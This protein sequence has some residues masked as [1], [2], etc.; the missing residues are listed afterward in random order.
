MF[1]YLSL[2]AARILP[3]NLTTAGSLELQLNDKYKLE[4]LEL[5]ILCQTQPSLDTVSSL[6]SFLFRWLPLVQLIFFF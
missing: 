4:A 6:I 2:A 1:M 3:I 5:K